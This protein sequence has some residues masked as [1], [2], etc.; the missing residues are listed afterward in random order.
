MPRAD[1][2]SGGSCPL[3]Q[4]RNL[5]MSRNLVEGGRAVPPLPSRRGPDRQSGQVKAAGGIWKPNKQAWQ[6]PYDR[7]IALGLM[8]RNIEDAGC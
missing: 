7:A 4:A 8:E 5:V 6:L 3:R 2:K 1:L